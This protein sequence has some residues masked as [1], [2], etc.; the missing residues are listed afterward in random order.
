MRWHPILSPETPLTRQLSLL[1][2]RQE[3]ATSRW[4]NIIIPMQIIASVSMDRHNVQLTF[5]QV[6]DR[7]LPESSFN[8][9]ETVFGMVLTD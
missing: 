4:K 6:P 2:T 3:T 9:E 1:N 5:R 8:L 7:S